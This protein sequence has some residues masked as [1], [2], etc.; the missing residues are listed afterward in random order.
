MSSFLRI[1]LS[2]SQ[3][4][5]LATNLVDSSDAHLSLSRI[6]LIVS[7]RGKVRADAISAEFPCALNSEL[8]F[9]CSFELIFIVSSIF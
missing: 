3:T 8:Y 4:I 1:F 7:T 6:L 5:A 9:P 2:I